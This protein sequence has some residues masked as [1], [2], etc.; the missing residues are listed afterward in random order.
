MNGAF[1]AMQSM[2]Q[3]SSTSMRNAME[4][5]QSAYRQAHTEM[6]NSYAN[7][8][9]VNPIGAKMCASCKNYDAQNYWCNLLVVPAASAT[10]TGGACYRYKYWELNIDESLK[11]CCCDLNRT[12]EEKAF[13]EAIARELETIAAI[14]SWTFEEQE[15]K[16]EMPKFSKIPDDVFASICGEP[17]KPPLELSDLYSLAFPFDPIQEH[18]AGIYKRID[19][20]YQKK[21]EILDRVK[22]EPVERFEPVEVPDNPKVNQESFQ[23]WLDCEKQVAIACAWIYAVILIAGLFL[24]FPVSI[25]NGTRFLVDMTAI[26]SALFLLYTSV[27]LIFAIFASRRKEK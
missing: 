15:Y 23:D 19:A 3:A 13:S 9:T 25:E 1:I 4:A 10:M 27:S 6:V 12:P 8:Y 5:N 7:C 24:A 20:E 22:V 17:Y 18:F 16:T 2:M 14:K 21:K 26:W 11:K